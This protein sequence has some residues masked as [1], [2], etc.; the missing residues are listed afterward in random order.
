MTPPP[1]LTIELVPQAQWGFNLRSELKP[2]D[3]DKLRRASY[4]KA[5]HKC[6]V[7]GGVGRNHNVE[8][9][10]IWQYDDT[11]HTQTLAG[12]V[13]LCPRCHE[14]K[15]FGRAMSLGHGDR[16]L[17]HL[18]RVNGWSMDQAVE[19]A[20]ESLLVWRERSKSGWELDITW[21]QQWL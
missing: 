13:S 6:E 5:G 16:A 1:K 15:H 18:A 19:H 21:V 8:C 9:H 14:V 17:T 20:R 11:H 12:L 7:C 2:K 4:E 10:E 3:W